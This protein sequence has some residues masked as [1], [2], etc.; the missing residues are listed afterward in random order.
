M[1][2]LVFLFVFCTVMVVIS[3][4]IIAQQEIPREVGMPTNIEEMKEMIRRGMQQQNECQTNDDCKDKFCPQIIGADKPRCINGRCVCAPGENFDPK[5]FNMTKMIE[6]R[7]LRANLREKIESGNYSEEELAKIREKYKECLPSPEKKVESLDVQKISAVVQKYREKKENLREEFLQSLSELKEM[8]VEAALDPNL[9]G[10]ELAERMKEIN[11]QKKQLVKEYVRRIKE[12]NLARQQELKEVIGELRIG[13]DVELAGEKI[14]V[15]KIVVKI[16]NK[17]V[18][19]NPGDKVEIKVEGAV[20][21]SVVPLKL[22]DEKL[23]DEVTNKSLNVT[24][25]EIG[26]KVKEKIKEVKLERKGNILIYSVNA[27]KPAKLIGIIPIDLQV[28]YEISAE[29][30][31]IITTEKPWW[32]F[33]AIG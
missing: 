4:A 2:N 27:E 14:N 30:G 9:S 12:I 22:K 11:E 33:L 3:Q 31:K 7:M 24:P 19:I 23:I 21:K 17:E 29:D 28:K 8:K 16:N 6:C 25:D 10:R 26:V 5:K 13:K 18:E 15:S 20:A 1:K 32:S